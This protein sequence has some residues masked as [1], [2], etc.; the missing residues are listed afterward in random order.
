VPVED[1]SPIGTQLIELILTA[2]ELYTYLL[3]N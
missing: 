3:S 2:E 1:N